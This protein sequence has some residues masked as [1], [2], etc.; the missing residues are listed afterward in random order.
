MTRLLT[1]LVSIIVLLT[2]A[3]CSDSL[4]KGEEEVNEPVKRNSNFIGTIKE[5]H[6][7]SALVHTENGGIPEGNVFVDL[8]VNNDE[9]FEIGDKIKIEFD[10]TILESNPAQV[11]TLFVELVD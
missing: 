1:V 5:I 10:G 9:T 7:Q 11:N 6:G 2:I 8:S 4:D 3:G